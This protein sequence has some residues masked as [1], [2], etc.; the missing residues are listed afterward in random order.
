[1]TFLKQQRSTFTK[2]VN[3]APA[4]D[5]EVKA[6]EN[7]VANTLTKGKVKCKPNV[8]SINSIASSKHLSSNSAW[9]FNLSK[10]YRFAKAAT[11]Q[12]QVST[13]KKQFE[14]ICTLLRAN[15]CDVIY[16]D[17]DFSFEQTQTIR[18]LQ[19]ESKTQLHSA[20]LAY[21]FEGN[22]ALAS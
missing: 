9:V 4:L 1:M 18:K 13:N 20:K 12:L 14:Y 3:S 8:K 2:H 11:R 5:V 10:H 21:L 7:N 6:L 19:K 16:F 15:N 17:E 22:L